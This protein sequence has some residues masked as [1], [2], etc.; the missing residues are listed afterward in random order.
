M[1][2]GDRHASLADGGSDAF[3]GAVADVA[4][5][6]DPRDARLEEIRV[7]V[8]LPSSR[9]AHVGAGEDVALRVECDLRW[10]PP[11]SASALMKMNRPP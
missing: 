7:T 6:E 2:E 10:E 8:E 9:G 5:G 4:A 3:H 1:H 11:V